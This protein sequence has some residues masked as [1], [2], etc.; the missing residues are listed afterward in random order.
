MSTQQQSERKAV[1][2]IIKQGGTILMIRKVR[3]MDG[4]AGAEA[5]DPI[6]SFPM[7]GIKSGETLDDAIWR[8]LLEETGSNRYRVVSRLPD[9]CFDFPTS[10]AAK[11]GTVSQRTHMFLVEYIGDGDDVAPQDDEIDKVEFHSIANAIELATFENV[12][13]YLREYA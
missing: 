8:E 6:W 1:G 7:G 5:I 13:A 4:K 11:L 3:M 12:K 10:V 2:A 9:F